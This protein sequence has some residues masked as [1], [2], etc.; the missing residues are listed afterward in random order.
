MLAKERYKD[1][2]KADV[3]IAA[4]HGSF[5]FFDKDRETARDNPSN[6]VSLEKKIKPNRILVS[7]SERFPMK[8][9]ENQQPPHYAAY[10]WYKKYLA[11]AR[12]CRK[13][14]EHPFLYSC[15]GNVRFELRNGKWSVKENWEPPEDEKK[16]GGGTPKVAFTP[17]VGVGE[18]A[19]RKFA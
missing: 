16:G 6:Y 11:D 4:H 14:D 19:P 10:K 17:V 2:A 15:D 3:L 8:D 12:L 18:H 5:T 13:E 7:S 1:W 9:E